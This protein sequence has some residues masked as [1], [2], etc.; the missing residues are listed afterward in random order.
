MDEP[1]GILPEEV[2]PSDAQQ[3]VRCELSKQRTRVIWGEGNPR[4][5]I[6]M[7]LDNPGAREDRQG[8]AFLCGTREMLQ[9]GMREVGLDM[10]SS[11]LRIC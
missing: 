9:R 6:M 4:A 3:C 11:T 1:F 8:D 5:K 7:I 10:D 2:G